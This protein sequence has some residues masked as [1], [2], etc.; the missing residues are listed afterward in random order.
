MD[1]PDSINNIRNFEKLIEHAESI[2]AAEEF[3]R[4]FLSRVCVNPQAPLSMILAMARIVRD[5]RAD[6]LLDQA[7][8]N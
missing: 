3:I 2:P 5:T 6:E 4:S 8:W 1:K 7:S